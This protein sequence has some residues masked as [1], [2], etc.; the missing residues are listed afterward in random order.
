MTHLLYS[1][2]MYIMENHQTNFIVHNTREIPLSGARLDDAMLTQ[3]AHNAD[4]EADD[5]QSD[6]S[7]HREAYNQCDVHLWIRKWRWFSECTN[8]LVK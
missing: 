1:S 2:D 5:H 4:Q 7:G 6:H 8:L 3:F